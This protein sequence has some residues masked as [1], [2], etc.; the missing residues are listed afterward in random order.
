MHFTIY[1]F[2]F[3]YFSTLIILGKSI[4]HFKHLGFIKSNKIQV[5][6]CCRCKEKISYFLTKFKSKIEYICQECINQNEI[7]NYKTKKLKNN[8]NSYYC[9]KCNKSFKFWNDKE[10]YCEI[11]YSNLNKHHNCGP[12]THSFPVVYYKVKNNLENLKKDKIYIDNLILELKEK[13]PESEKKNPN[14]L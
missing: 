4:K 6:L 7:N 11:C 9:K 10:P 13:Y 2:L 1:S 3:T 12:F 8:L 14:K 5:P